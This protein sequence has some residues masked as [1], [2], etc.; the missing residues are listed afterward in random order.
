MANVDYIYPEHPFGMTF[1]PAVLP[2]FGPKAA[3]DEDDDLYKL[4]GVRV[5]DVVHDNR[6][7]WD[8][9]HL[10]PRT[11]PRFEPP[12]LKQSTLEI[13]GGNGA[14]DLSPILSYFPLFENRTGSFEFIV[15]EFRHVRY[16]GSNTRRVVEDSKWQYEY[17]D[18]LNFFQGRVRGCILDED[19]SYAYVGKFSVNSFKAEEHWTSFSLEYDVY[20]YR[21][22]KP[23]VKT[24]DFYAAPNTPRQGY[25]ITNLGDGPVLTFEMKANENSSGTVQIA[26]TTIELTDEYVNYASYIDQKYL[27]DYH[28]VPFWPTGTGSFNVRY[29]GTWL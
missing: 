1:V 15:P 26:N 6:H 9:W 28:R 27:S 21:V 4:N 17:W 23:T 13:P 22:Y 29:I 8:D 25:T 24:Y 14:I 16:P 19:P 7:T 3:F 10:I 12:Q 5:V 20:P 18:M 2:P 11:R